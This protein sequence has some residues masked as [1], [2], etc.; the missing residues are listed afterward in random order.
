MMWFSVVILSATLVACATMCEISGFAVFSPCVS[1]S[2]LVCAHVCPFC[3]PVDM[4]LFNL[5]AGMAE[6]SKI[7]LYLHAQFAELEPES[8][9]G[10]LRGLADTFILVPTR[11]IEPRVAIGVD[12]RTEIILHILRI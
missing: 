11:K 6:G 4:F 10:N 1:L 5:R 12:I 8:L 3:L 9:A 7:R 2:D